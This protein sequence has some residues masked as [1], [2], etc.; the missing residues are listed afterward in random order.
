[1][2]V[3]KKII[4][5]VFE[6]RVEKNPN[7]ISIV[8]NNKNI[9]YKELNSRANG[10]GYHLNNSQYIA[11]FLPNSIDYIVTLLAILKVGS[12]FVP[13]DILAPND[14]IY[15]IIKKADIETI[16]TNLENLKNL[17]KILKTLQLDI[18]I[19]IL[20]DIE[21]RENNLE[22]KSKED[23][24]AYLMFTSGSTGE[25]KAIIGMQKSLSHFIHWESKEFKIDEKFKISQIAGVTFDVSLRDIFTALITGATLYIPTERTNIEYLAKW[26]DESG[27]TLI[28]IVP[29]LFRLL[30]KEFE[31]KNYKLSDLQHILLAGE[32]LYGHDVVNFN[33]L[34][35]NIELVNL[36]GPSETTLAKIY[37]RINIENIKNPNMIIPLGKAISNTAILILKGN[38]LAGVKQIGEIYIKTPF[39]SKGYLKEPQLTQEMFIQNPL[40]SKEDIIY[41]TGDMGRYQADGTVEFIGRVDNQVKINGIRVELQEIEIAIKSYP[42]IDNAIIITEISPSK[43]IVIIC[44]FIEKEKFIEDAIREYLIEVIPS[45]MIPNFFIKMDSFPLNFHGKI[46]KKSL[47][48]PEDLIYI[49]KKF[50]EP[51]GKIEQSVADIFSQILRVK[52]I[53]ADITFTELGGNSLNSISATAKISHTFGVQINIKEFFENQSVKKLAKLIDMRLHQNIQKKRIK[54]EVTP[55]SESYELSNSQRRLWVLD[56]IQN[57]SGVY[58]IAGA[59][60]FDREL[61]RDILRDTIDILV[62]RHEILRTNFITIKNSPRQIVKDKISNDIFNSI[63]VEDSQKYIQT[64]AERAFD[65]ESDVLFYIKLINSHILFINMHHIISDGWSIGVIIKELSIIYTA[66]IDK[67]KPILPSLDIQYKDY[68]YWQNSL[69]KNRDYLE[70]HQNYWHNLLKNPVN[71]N[72]P[73]DYARPTKQTFDGAS[74]HFRLNQELMKKIVNLS[75]SAT[76]FTFLFTITNI[77]ISKYTNQNE[78]I[79]GTTVA[80]REEEALFNQIGFY[81]NTL[82]LKTILTP[83]DSFIKNLKRIHNNCLEAFSHQSYPF[84][85]L[86]DELNLERDISQNPLFN[87]MMILQNNENVDIKF[88]DLKANARDIELDISKFDMT[89]SFFEI[90]DELELVL[91]YNTNLFNK[92]TIQNICLNLETLIESIDLDKPLNQ[93]KFISKIEQNRLDSFNSIKRDY[94]INKTIIELFE[95]Q[96]IKNPHNIALLYENKKISY[97]ELNQKANQIAHHLIGTYHVEEETIIPIILERSDL[98]ISS[99]LG[100]L[101][102]SSAYLPIDSDYPKD[103]VRYMLQDSKS[104]FI[105]TD[106][107]NFEKISDYCSDLD[108]QVICVDDIKNTKIDNLA[109]KRDASNLAYVIYT[110]GTTGQPKGVMVEHR[111]FINMILYQIESFNIEPKDNIIQFASFSF[112]A[113]VY[114]TFLT[115]LAGASYVLVKKDELLDNFL[116]I[117]KKYNINTAVLNPTFLANIDELENFKTIITAGEKALT[118]D[119]IKYAKRCNYINAYGPTEVS[120]CSAFYSV[121]SNKHYKTIPIGKSIA[122]ISNYI[123]NDE[124]EQMPIGAVGQIYTG[125]IGLARGYLNR[126][127]LSKE[128]FIEH[129]K[130]GRLYATGDIG[131][132]DIEGNI[133]YLGRIDTQI[134]LRGHRIE[135]SEIENIILEYPSIKESVIKIVKEQLIAY[136]IGNRDEL[137]IFIKDKLPNYM[138]P[139]Y[140][141]D[142]DSFPLTPN[143]KIDTKALPIPKI[144][145]KGRVAPSSKLED[146]LCRVYQDILGVEVG[147]ED[148][149]FDFG[150]DSIKAIQISSRLVEVGYKVEVKDIFSYPKIIQL[151]PFVKDNKRIIAQKE[152]IGKIK[153][154][155]IQKWFFKLKD[156]NKNHFNQDMLLE[157]DKSIETTDIKESITLLLQHHDILRASYKKG[158]QYIQSISDTKVELKEFTIVNESEIFKITEK[159]NSS[160]NISKVPLIKFALIVSKEK[161]Y[162]YIATHHLIIDGVSWRILMEDLVSLYNNRK[163]PLKTDSFMTYSKRLNKYKDNIEDEKQL[164]EKRCIDFKLKVDNKVKKRLIKNQKSLYFNFSKDITRDLL[165]NVNFAYN[166]TTQDILILALNKALFHSFG[167]RRSVIGL[168]SHGREDILGLNLSRTVG[169]FTALYPELLK[170]S[171]TDLSTQIKLQKESLRETPHN[172]IGYGIL[173]YLA[174]EDLNFSKEILFNYLGQFEDDKN[175]LFKMSDKK[176]A[177]TLSKD[178]ISEF[179]LDISLIITNKQLNI[180]IQYDKNEYNKSTIEIFLD[181]YKTSLIE[182]IDHCKNQKSMELTPYD[183]D[184]EDFDIGSLSEFLDNLEVD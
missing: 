151:I 120:I 33:K 48:K 86:V 180:S 160:L 135:L 183:I 7:N 137:E 136:I 159:L 113:S 118:K 105:L 10:V 61:D 175:S 142:M 168:E 91:E 67:K 103:R 139:S 36:Y 39:R 56:K 155:P 124:L 150:G 152:I 29:S 15:K 64:E 6:N 173:K 116:E 162:L 182:I 158:K 145:A 80:N 157:I 174:K 140:I 44:Y 62:N 65:L 167:L 22:L 20:E 153:L 53:S 68:T 169:W 59:I 104:Q 55:K 126:E 34:Y 32:A 94:P 110:S 5:T 37:N 129:S 1:M 108:I 19:L 172:G 74:Y 3:N 88:S 170:Y 9:S 112:D 148:S 93:L 21:P 52:K 25:P 111:S 45:Y 181:N 147:V 8:Y 102:T 115:L 11:I 23:S 164:W 58:N 17:K 43:E 27:L 166:T 122:N 90:D 40:S 109:I 24:S 184:D 92:R 163:L 60:E 161:N 85:K 38:R 141:I 179:K 98:M 41:K 143:G 89:F 82:A 13:M 72:F 171:D 95:E 96:V 54:I 127:L 78:L 81:T 101:K 79:L 125:G 99:L 178:F 123:L 87:I 100:V 76:L 119:A 4:H 77:L 30:V 28:H 57:T 134:K 107:V 35:P 66:L 149:F 73:L 50:I 146:I 47:P 63:E 131:K 84:D 46:D 133:E 138:I 2:K 156:I 14:R 144:E 177:S 42:K 51:K 83:N 165:E 70:E 154:T 130:L 69:L 26:I 12:I 114:E 117:T 71:V 121:N 106:R 31:Y 16:I 97:S 75:D 128:K 49:D 132:Y 18:N 176:T